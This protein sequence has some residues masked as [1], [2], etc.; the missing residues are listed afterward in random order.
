MTALLLHFARGPSGRVLG[1]FAKAFDQVF[2]QVV[3]AYV[4]AN[5]LARDAQRRYPFVGE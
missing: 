5:A 4:D 1:R 2:D 3:R